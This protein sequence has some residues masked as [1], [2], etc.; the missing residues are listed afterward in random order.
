MGI[1]SCS[2]STAVSN[3]LENLG[4]M[5]NATTNL[6]LM[7]NYRS[8]HDSYE[9]LVQEPC[10]P[11]VNGMFFFFLLESFVAVICLPVMVCTCQENLQR[12]VSQSLLP[13]YQGEQTQERAA[14]TI[15]AGAS[16][17]PV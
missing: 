7:L 11:M 6:E 16:I 14:D 3:V 1:T 4:A 9:K 15:D 13:D 17:I 2:S 10:P 5:Q 12:P 8:V